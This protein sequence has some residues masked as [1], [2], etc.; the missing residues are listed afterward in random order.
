MVNLPSISKINAK[1]NTSNLPKI[2][3]Q[4]FPKDTPKQVSLK[5]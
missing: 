5:A 1:L 4:N 3:Q 2:N